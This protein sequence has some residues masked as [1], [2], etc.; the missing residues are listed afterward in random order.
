VNPLQFALGAA[1]HAHPSPLEEPVVV[2]VVVFVAMDVVSGFYRELDVH[3]TQGVYALL[4]NVFGT[5]LTGTPTTR[6]LPTVDSPTP[7]VIGVTLYLTIVIGGLIWIKA[8]DLKPRVVEPL[9]LQAL[10]L[11]HNLFC[12]GLSLYMC[13][14]IIY[15][16]VTHKYSLWGN[17]Y[18][19]EHKEMAILTY[20]FYMS[21]YVEFMD[22]VIMI[23]KRSTRQI[24]VLHVYHHSSISLIWWAIA[25]HAP[26]G[27]AYFS[28]ALNSGVHVFM[29]AYY[30]LAACLR[31]NPKLRAKY[32]FWGRYLTQFQMFQ[33]ML[34]LIQAYY[35]IKIKAP[36]PQWLIKILFYYMISLLCLFGNFYVQKY[37]VSASSSKEKGD[38]TE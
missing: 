2:V 16:A 30:F 13:V 17:A 23:M 28:A 33:F 38:K 21:K 22:T 4:R 32:L 34:N 11:V 19:P 31:S 14:G 27:E 35:D 25:H 15:Q 5:E 29:Y 26:G 1:S 6:G 24:S 18:N 3:V 37:I 10:V 12:F 7:I 8:R 20:L 9:G 36:Y